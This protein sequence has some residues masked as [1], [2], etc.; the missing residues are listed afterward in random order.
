MS[1][2]PTSKKKYINPI[3]DTIVSILCLIIIYE[4]LFVEKH[5]WRAAIF[6]LLLIFNIADIIKFWKNKSKSD[7]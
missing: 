5:Y 3:L 1:K 2:S 6:S 4:S 7:I